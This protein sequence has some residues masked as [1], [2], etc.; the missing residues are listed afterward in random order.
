MDG[1]RI[2]RRAAGEKK[3]QQIE[4]ALLEGKFGFG[5]FEGYRLRRFETSTLSR[6]TASPAGLV[7]TRIR[8][9][10]AR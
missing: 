10:A 3:W 9:I 6:N 8:A 7:S 4:K 5:G 2:E 1:S